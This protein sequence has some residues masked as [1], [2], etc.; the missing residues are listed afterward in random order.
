MVSSTP[1]P[2]Y[3]WEKEPGPTAQEAGWAQKWPGRGGE[4]KILWTCWKSN[5]CPTA[6]SLVTIT[7]CKARLQN[8]RKH[9]ASWGGHHNF[10]ET[11]STDLNL[12]TGI[13]VLNEASS[14]LDQ[15]YSTVFVRVP[16]D[17]ISLQL[18]TPKVVSV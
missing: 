17:I 8:P 5:P 6:H 14:S 9:K 1:K 12:R 7:E 13:Y 4:G 16:P 11:L 18:C 2:L 3:L 10:S 15:W